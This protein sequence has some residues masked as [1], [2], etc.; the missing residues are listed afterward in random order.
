MKYIIIYGSPTD[1]FAYI[2]PFESQEAATAH[3]NTDG[4]LDYNWWVA[5]L[6]AP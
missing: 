2:G 1:G 5:P 4:N 6:E 3:G